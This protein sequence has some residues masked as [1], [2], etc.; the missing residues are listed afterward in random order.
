[1]SIS[2]RPG[3]VF[4]TSSSICLLALLLAAPA[5]AAA[6]DV[7]ATRPILVV[8][9]VDNEYVAVRSDLTDATDGMLGGRKISQGKVDSAEVVVIRT[10]GVKHTRPAPRRKR[11]SGFPPV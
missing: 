1:M 3:R 9:A 4:W 2:T 5:K 8:T 11:S 10:A 6:G 7:A